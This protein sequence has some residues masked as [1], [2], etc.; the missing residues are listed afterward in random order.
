ESV[1][2]CWRMERGGR[3]ARLELQG[4]SNVLA[5]ATESFRPHAEA[6]GFRLDV[7]LQEGLPP[8]LIDGDAI[9]QVVL[10]LLSNAV[11]YSDDVRA[12]RVRACRDGP[13]A[14]FDVVDRGIGIEP[15]EIPKLFQQF[16]RADQ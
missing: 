10:N 1:R 4:H 15:R 11:K 9:T 2:A 13:W 14:A 5:T 7:E 12:I 6:E 3:S 16:Y 8:L